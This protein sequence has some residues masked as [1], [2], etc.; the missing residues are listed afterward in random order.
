MSADG[1]VFLLWKND[2][3]C[4]GLPVQIFSQ[5]LRSDGLAVAA[6]PRALVA[7]DRSWEAGV[8]EAPAMVEHEGTHYLFYSGN[9]WN[10]AQYAVG[11]ATCTGPAGPCRK[12]LNRPWLSSTEGVSGPGGLELF[13]GGGQMHAVFHAWTGPVG[14]DAGGV[15]SLFT[16]GVEFAD[17]AP[18]TAW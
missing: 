3:N 7:P 11:Y 8:V 15:R 13:D 6:P 4:C 16:V 2:G 5:P 12:P 9:A 14:Y 18:V 10:T 1:D 17:G